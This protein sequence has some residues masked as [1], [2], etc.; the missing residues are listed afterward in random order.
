M[1][2]DYGDPVHVPEPCQLEPCAL[3]LSD[4][5]SPCADARHY[6]GWGLVAYVRSQG[7][8]VRLQVVRARARHWEPPFPPSS[9]PQPRALTALTHTHPPSSRCP[10]CPQVQIGP[11]VTLTLAQLVFETPPSDNMFRAPGLPFLRPSSAG[12][13]TG[14][15]LLLRDSVVWS[16]VCFPALVRTAN[17]GGLARVWG[18][19]G[20]LQQAPSERDAACMW[21]R[22][23]SGPA[24]T[25]AAH[26]A[27]ALCSRGHRAH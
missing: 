7:D 9:P 12:P 14:A 4:C 10:P 24:A 8:G 2:S 1:K 5:A 11:G 27:Q 3:R 26:Q 16:A 15:R 17:A 22:R 21:V 19:E 18:W 20:G 6:E 23:H 25:A 13:D